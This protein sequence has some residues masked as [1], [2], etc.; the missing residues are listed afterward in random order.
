MAVN[1]AVL[2]VGTPIL[3]EKVKIFVIFDFSIYAD[4]APPVPGKLCR[5]QAAHSGLGAEFSW[6]MRK[7]EPSRLGLGKM[8]YFARGTPHL[9]VVPVN[10]PLVPVKMAA[11]PVK[12][13]ALPVGTPILSQILRKLAYFLQ[14]AHPF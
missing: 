11:L 4:F 9:A 13:A 3:A 10:W 2:P 7:L 12:M 1:L 6:K 8:A 5:A 14:L